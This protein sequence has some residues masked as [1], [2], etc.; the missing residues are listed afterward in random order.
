MSNAC[1]IAEY[2]ST[3]GFNKLHWIWLGVK[4]RDTDNHHFPPTV[5]DLDGFSVNWLWLN[6]ADDLWH[7]QQ[8]GFPKSDFFRNPHRKIYTHIRMKNGKWHVARDTYQG[9]VLCE[10]QRSDRIIGDLQDCWF[11]ETAEFDQV[12]YKGEIAVTEDGFD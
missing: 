1:C 10:H 11:P 12:T 6:T 8:A 5:T 2:F 7:D 9:A 3:L 4:T